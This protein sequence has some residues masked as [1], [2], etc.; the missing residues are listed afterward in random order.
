M[1]E[2]VARDLLA[3]ARIAEKPARTQPCTEHS[4][5]F[6]CKLVNADRQCIPFHVGAQASVAGC[7]FSENRNRFAGHAELP[8]F[9][10]AGLRWS[11]TLVFSSS[12]PRLGITLGVIFVL[13]FWKVTNGEG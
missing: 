7:H 8:V 12:A 1:V 13:N 11:L 2:D 9:G 4:R 10:W 6:V 3:F 5:V